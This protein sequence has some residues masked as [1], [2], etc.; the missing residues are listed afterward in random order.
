MVED[1]KIVTQ[2]DVLRKI[3]KLNPKLYDE[4]LENEVVPVVKPFRKKGM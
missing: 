3:K 1:G 2:S 4:Y